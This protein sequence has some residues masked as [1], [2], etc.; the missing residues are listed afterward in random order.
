MRIDPRSV[1]GIPYSYGGPGYTTGYGYQY[2]QTQNYSVQTE[3]SRTRKNPYGIGDYAKDILLGGVLGGLGGAAFYG[4][5]RAFD[6]LKRSVKKPKKFVA[7]DGGDG[8]GYKPS[9]NTK[10][11]TEPEV[12]NPT[13]IKYSDTTDA[14]DSYLGKNQ[15]DINPRTG[16]VDKNRLFSAVG[17]RSIRFSKHEM[18]SIGTTKA[19]FHYETWNY[20]SQN[21]VITITNTLQRMR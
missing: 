5:G 7:G 18:D 19:H 14:W 8:S 3:T 9:E 11:I 13:T 16:L 6:A 21:D 12:K 4:A 15:T 17:T 20:D 1:C 10:I 2:R